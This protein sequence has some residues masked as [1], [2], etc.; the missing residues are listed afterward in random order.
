[1]KIPILFTWTGAVWIFVSAASAQ[2]IPPS[3]STQTAQSTS[4]TTPPLA[5]SVKPPKQVLYGDPCRAEL[6]KFCVGNHPLAIRMRC[7]DSH[8]AEFS[9]ACQKRRVE[10]RE[11]RS[12]CQAVID[13]SCRYTPLLADAILSCLQEHEADIVDPSCKSLREK[14]AQSSHYIAAACQSDVKKLCKDVPV[15]GFR[16][17]QCL[18]EH[19][20]D[21]SKPCLAGTS[22]K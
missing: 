14:A 1:M 4:A 16:I 20:T 3:Q 12:S 10:L 15:N 9:E 19:E 5:Q 6:E 21:L 17:A 8:E 22:E 7:L 13:Q 11:L 18:Q 2:P